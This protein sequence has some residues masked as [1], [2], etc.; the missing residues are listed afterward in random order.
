MALRPSIFAL[1]CL[2]PLGGCVARQMAFRSE[3]SGSLVYL[4]GQEIGRTPCTYDF[5]WY[6]RYDL[7]LR[8]DGYQTVKT[9]QN[10]AAPWWQWIPLDLAA[11]VTPARFVDKREY[12]YNLQIQPADGVPSAVLID[13]AQSLK[14]LLESGEFTRKPA[15][16]PTTAPANPTTLPAHGK[17]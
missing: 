6:G 13:R 17:Q 8:K 2:L 9:T 7:T 5:T 14:P 12:S 3:P 15:T 11:E 10:V 4:N 1:V 16:R